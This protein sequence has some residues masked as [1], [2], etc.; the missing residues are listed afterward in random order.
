MFWT[1]DQFG[2]DSTCETRVAKGIAMASVQQTSGLQLVFASGATSACR[3][4]R[5]RLHN[6]ACRYVT[7]LL[8][9]GASVVAAA[10]GANA[11]SEYL[12][13]ETGAT[14]FFVGQPLVFARERVTLNGRVALRESPSGPADMTHVPRDYVTLAAAA[15]DRGGKYTYVLVG[16]FWFVVAP[17][18]GENVCFEREHLVLQFG[19]R[20]IELAPFD[21]SARDAGISQ[22]IHR[23]SIGDA[24][25]A[26]YP[27]DFATLGQIAESARPVLY[28]EA[29]TA[30]L[31]YKLL[32][33]RLPALRE[34]LRHLSD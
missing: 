16:Y 12:D 25:P 34:L 8:L 28:C 24:K 19:D 21:G 15:V 7:S 29:E 3:G 4:R 30:P 14:V 9:L 26:V 10:S 6:A 5:Q 18:P 2:K 31:K 13:E 22:P 1:A 17:Q 23:P 27:I 33:D 11:P 32:E 20:R